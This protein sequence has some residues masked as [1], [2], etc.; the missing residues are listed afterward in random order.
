VL[1]LPPLLGGRQQF[2]CRCSRR[3]MVHWNPPCRKTGI[4]T[5]KR[6]QTPRR[7]RRQSR[8]CN[9]RN[10]PA[11]A[12]LFDQSFLTIVSTTPTGLVSEHTNTKHI[13]ETPAFTQRR[14]STHFVPSNQAC[15]SHSIMTPPRAAKRRHNTAWGA[16]PRTFRNPH[17][18]CQLP[19][20]GYR[21]S[22]VAGTRRVPSAAN[23]YEGAASREAAT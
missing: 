1:F 11:S 16:S 7:S 10:L 4:E 9:H 17:A 2:S 18:H 19:S 6:L 8:F 5:S 14:A 23:A 13:Q 15:V 3:Y 20:E 22:A 12:R 21:K